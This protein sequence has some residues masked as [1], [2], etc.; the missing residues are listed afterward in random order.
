MKTHTI[1]INGTAIELKFGFG[2]L[3]LLG[4]KWGCAGPVAVMAHFGGAIQGLADALASVN[5][6]DA[7]TA[8][9]AVKK[10]PADTNIDIPFAAVDAL[11]DVVTTA[12]Q[13]QK[14]I[15][16]DADDVAQWMLENPEEMTAIVTLFM[17]SLP[18]QRPAEK[19]AAGAKEN[20]VNNL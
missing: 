9:E 1:T 13:A 6:T 5:I 4:D 18:V 10:L 12:V 2:F 7:A 3:R 16:P 8:E 19:K 17:Q 15:V 20:P 11:T 14:S